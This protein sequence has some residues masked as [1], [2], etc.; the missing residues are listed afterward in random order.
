MTD[1]AQS[2]SPS[3]NDEDTSKTVTLTPL[4]DENEDLEQ[5]RGPREVEVITVDMNSPTDSPR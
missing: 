1:L 2:G 3:S 4:E 5:G